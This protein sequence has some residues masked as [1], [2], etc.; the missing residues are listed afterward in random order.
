MA[1]IARFWLGDD[2]EPE[3]QSLAAVARRRRTRSRALVEMVY[4][5]LLMARRRPGAMAHLERAF[6]EARHLL[7]P[8]DYF[9]VLKRHSLLAQLPPIEASQGEALDALLTT[10]RVIARLAG[11]R[12]RAHDS[13]DTSA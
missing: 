9:I 4:G 11:Q 6:A 2:V 13:G 8:E 1:L 10:A 12:R 3:Y 5:Q 7:A